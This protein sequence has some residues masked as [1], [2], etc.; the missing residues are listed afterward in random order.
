MSQELIDRASAR[1]ARVLS[2]RVAKAVQDQLASLWAL[3]GDSDSF[4]RDAVLLAEEIM[5]EVNLRDADQ[6]LRFVRSVLNETPPAG[7]D[8]AGYVAERLYRFDPPPKPPDFIGVAE[9]RS[10]AAN[11]ASAG[12]R[13]RGG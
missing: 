5:R 9:E 13:V 7:K 4:R 2:P 10:R 3:R 12:E 8:R 6:V 1:A 11:V